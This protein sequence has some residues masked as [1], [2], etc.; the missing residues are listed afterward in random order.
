MIYA[1]LT[2]FNCT[3]TRTQPCTFTSLNFITTWL[4]EC[5]A[6]LLFNCVEFQQLWQP[7]N[8]QQQTI[9]IANRFAKKV[10]VLQPHWL[11]YGRW[12]SLN[13]LIQSG[14]HRSLKTKRI[15]FFVQFAFDFDS[16]KVCERGPQNSFYS[17]DCSPAPILVYF[18]VCFLFFCVEFFCSYS[19]CVTLSQLF[20]GL[21]G[22]FVVFLFAVAFGI[23]IIDIFDLI[24]LNWFRSVI[25]RRERCLFQLNSIRPHLFICLQQV[26]V[27]RQTYGAISPSNKIPS[28]TPGGVCSIEIYWQSIDIGAFART[29]TRISPYLHFFQFIHLFVL[30]EI[31][32]NGVRGLHIAR[33]SFR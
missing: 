3:N 5:L 33:I 28:R 13:S 10:V 11:S 1:N 9:Q 31:Q 24:N 18:I 2:R 19:D 14:S 4:C 8:S 23:T 32:L 20:G 30:L 22:L 21:I 15:N 26:F 16:S 6:I 17:I 27:H 12:T 7:A 25:V 29:N